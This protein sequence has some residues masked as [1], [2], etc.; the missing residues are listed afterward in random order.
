MDDKIDPRILRTKHQL[1]EALL[2]LTATTPMDKITI[3]QLTDHAGLNRGT[4]YLHYQNL[5]DFYDDLK[6]DALD[7]YYKIIRKLAYPYENRQQFIDPPIGFIKPFEY[8]LENQRF[9]KVF[10]SPSGNG[11][12]EQMVDLIKKQF[13]YAYLIRNYHEA[14]TEIPVKQLYLFAYLASAYVG[15]LQYWIQRDFDLSPKEMAILFS[16]IS[17]RGSANV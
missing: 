7:Q 14:E 9:F 13:E 3:K 16:E 12:T 11:F 15:S 5:E 6:E 2:D 17:R 4:F 1:R 10:M 8:I